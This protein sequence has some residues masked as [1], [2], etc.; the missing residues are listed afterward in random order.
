MAYQ[1]QGKG[2]AF[3]N[4]IKQKIFRDKKV[5]YI[6][7]TEFTTMGRFFKVIW[8]NLNFG[9]YFYYSFC[10]IMNFKKHEITFQDFYPNEKT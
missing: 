9:K 8:G 7:D 4:P 6:Y 1:Y 10:L 5:Q 2:A 3:R